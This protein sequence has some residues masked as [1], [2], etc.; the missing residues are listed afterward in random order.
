MTLLPSCFRLVSQFR[1]RSQ[2]AK[3]VQIESVSASKKTFHQISFLRLFQVD[4]YNQECSLVELLLFR[5][6]VSDVFDTLLHCDKRFLF[7]DPIS[8]VMYRSGGSLLISL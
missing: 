2:I 5:H 4:I 3:F 6:Q 8:N 7:F 1:R